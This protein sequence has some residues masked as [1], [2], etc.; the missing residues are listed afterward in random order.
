MAAGDWF[1]ISTAYLPWTLRV[2]CQELAVDS[3]IWQP[4]ARWKPYSEFRSCDEW[5]E[6]L[7]QSTERITCTQC[8]HTYLL[9][10]AMTE[11]WVRKQHE[12]QDVPDQLIQD[13]I[14][15]CISVNPVNFEGHFARR[16]CHYYVARESVFR[17][18]A[19]EEPDWV[20]D[21]SRRIGALSGKFSLGLVNRENRDVFNKLS[22]ILG[23]LTWC[24][25]SVIDT[26]VASVRP[27]CGG[28]IW[29]TTD[30]HTVLTLR[31]A[32]QPALEVAQSTP[33][34]NQLEAVACDASRNRY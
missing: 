3:G 17:Q 33:A 13:Y 12:Q 1:F 4:S 6:H 21:V 7:A 31:C 27:L 18:A 32:I 8:M 28:P 16:S 26:A 19:L 29:Y 5:D 2:T 14:G 30:K 22:R 34:Q 11:W 10:D 23:C 9:P 20:R 24:Y 15:Q 25:V